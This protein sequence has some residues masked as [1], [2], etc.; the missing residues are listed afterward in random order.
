MKTNQDNIKNR[1][2]MGSGPS[3]SDSPSDNVNSSI[4]S[5]PT[6]TLRTSKN[7][8]AKIIKNLTPLLSKIRKFKNGDFSINY[9]KGW[10]GV[11]VGLRKLLQLDYEG[12][13]NYANYETPKGILSLRLAD[14]NANGNNYNPENINMSVFVALI[15]YP[16]IPSK[17]EYT[18]FRIAQETYDKMP[19]DVVYAIV[20]ATEQAL[21]GEAFTINTDI[22]EIIHYAPETTSHSPLLPASET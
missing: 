8:A 13:S 15:E 20:K 10:N 19:K 14:H 16:N 9:S 11:L 21:N 7:S 17:I 12:G 6:D 18:E 2:Q 1:P 3:Y 22:A 5:S 4:T